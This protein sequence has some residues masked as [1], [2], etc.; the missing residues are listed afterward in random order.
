M[1]MYTGIYGRVVL[2]DVPSSVRVFLM[3]WFWRWDD[4]EFDNKPDHP[5]F[6][7]DRWDTLLYGGSAYFPDCEYGARM[8][9]GPQTITLEL[10]ASLKN[11]DEEI[12]K[13]LDWIEPYRDSGTIYY[14]YEENEDWTQA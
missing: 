3:D 9:V 6:K 13:F 8:T 12:E 10:S 11:Y 1:G 5:F 14:R 7:T 4:Q 2:K